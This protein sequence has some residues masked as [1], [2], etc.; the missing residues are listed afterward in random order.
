MSIAPPEM[1]SARNAAELLRDP[2]ARS[3]WLA[4]L[5]AE[6]PAYIAALRGHPPATMHPL[7]QAFYPELGRLLGPAILKTLE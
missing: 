2:L 3:A 6:R 4:S 1:K 7:D 5:G